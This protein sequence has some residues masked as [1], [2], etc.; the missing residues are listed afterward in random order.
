MA[1]VRR[2]DVTWSGDLA[3]GQGQSQRAAAAACSRVSTSAGRAA[4]SRRQRHHQ[5]RGAAGRGARQLLRHGPSAGLGRAGTPP[6]SLNVERDGHLRPRRRRLQGR[7]ERARSARPG[8]RTSTRPRS[9]RP[10][11]RAKDGCPISQA[12]EGQRR[13]ERQSHPGEV[14][15]PSSA[16]SSRWS[17]A[18][19][20]ASAA[21]SR[22]SSPAAARTC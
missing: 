16:A 11:K 13:A 22:S 12:P 8:A 20:A 3:S 18:A 15:R 5:P 7:L 19:G 17:P 9:S 10:P 1:A 14:E 2:A 4:P 6:E 21:P